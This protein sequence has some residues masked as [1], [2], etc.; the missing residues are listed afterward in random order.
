M[1]NVMY[2]YIQPAPSYFKLLVILNLYIAATDPALIYSFSLIALAA[3][4]IYFAN[5]KLYVVHFSIFEL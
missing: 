5:F 4:L 1:Y 2:R 3:Y